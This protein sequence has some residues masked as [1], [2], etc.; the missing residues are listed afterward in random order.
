MKMDGHFNKNEEPAIS[1][2]V[3]P[4]EIE[5]LVDTGFTGGLMIPEVLANDLNLKHGGA[6]GE[7]QSATG[8]RIPVSTYR[9]EIDWLGRRITIPVAT[10]SQSENRSLA[11][12]C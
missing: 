8:E 7:F 11:G 9:M 3:G 1:L 6:L 12:T 4:L 5:F 10:S 2:D